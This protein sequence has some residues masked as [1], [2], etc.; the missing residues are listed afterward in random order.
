MSKNETGHPIHDDF[1]NK[2]W[3]KIVRTYDGYYIKCNNRNKSREFNALLE[4][5]D[6][7]YKVTNIRVY[8]GMVDVS[9]KSKR[10]PMRFIY[11]RYQGPC[12]YNN[13]HSR[14]TWSYQNSYYINGNN[15]TKE[16]HNKYKLLKT[17]ENL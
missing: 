9:K 1:L 14:S 8:H 11:H 2:K 6:Q 10:L 17:M 5:H 15:V 4:Q 13:V 3:V 7:P 16:Y 12:I